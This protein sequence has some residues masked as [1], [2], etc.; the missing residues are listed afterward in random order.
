M[1]QSGDLVCAAD[2]MSDLIL[3]LTHVWMQG[4][5]GHHVATKSTMN[6]SEYMEDELRI[7]EDSY[8]KQFREKCDVKLLISQTLPCVCIFDDFTDKLQFPVT[9][10]K[11]AILNS[12]GE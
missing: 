4:R 11:E 2:G 5:E 12:L 6:S 1:S 3:G 10:T 7:T 8:L 9:R